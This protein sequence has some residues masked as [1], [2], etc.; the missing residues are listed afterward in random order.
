MALPWPGTR[1]TLAIG[2][3]LKPP[4]ALDDREAAHWAH[5]I[6]SAIRDCAEQAREGEKEKK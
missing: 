2:P 1:V 6:E 4:A 5:R 3:P